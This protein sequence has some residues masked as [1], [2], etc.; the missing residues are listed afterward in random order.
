MAN[1]TILELSFHVSVL[2]AFFHV[3]TIQ[4][5]IPGETDTYGGRFKSLTYLNLYLS[6]GYYTLCAFIDLLYIFFDKLSLRHKMR[7]VSQL[8][9]FRN[10][11]DYLYS[12][13]VFPTSVTICVGF[14]ALTFSPFFHVMFEEHAKHV[15]LHSAMNHGIHTLPLLAT[16]LELVL[17]NHRM[18]MP[19]MQGILGWVV[20]LLSYLGWITWCEYHAGVWAYPIMKGMEVKFRIVAVVCYAL[21]QAILYQIG[22]SAT[23]KYWS[24]KTH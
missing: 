11:R 9:K 19:L 7:L 6:V 4:V 5:D 14:W 23:R 2:V 20:C 18:Q 3:I 10:T 22:V 21:L 12:S 1:T 16:V 13:I 8:R 24:I 17:T 15:A